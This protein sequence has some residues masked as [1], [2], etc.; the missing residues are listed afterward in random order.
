MFPFFAAGFLTTEGIDREIGKMRSKI[1]SFEEHCATAGLSLQQV[2]A[3]SMK[4]RSLFLKKSGEFNWFFKK[5]R[6]V[7]KRGSFL[8]L[9]AGLDDQMAELLAKRGIKHVNQA[10]KKNLLKQHLFNFYYSPL[11]NTFRTKYRKADLPLTERGARATKSAGI[12]VLVHGHVNQHNGQRIALKNG[13]VH[14]EA[15]ITLDSHSR[16]REGLDGYGVGVTLID[17]KRGVIGLSCDHPR[18]KVFKPNKQGR[19]EEKR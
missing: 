1:N 6:L 11:A 4:C 5:M 15:D 9:H 8:F 7:K 14:I 17:R 19:L 3:A 13:L 16:K 10:F 18:A 2:Y 12:H